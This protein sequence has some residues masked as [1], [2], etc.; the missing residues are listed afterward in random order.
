[1][2]L[3]D[4]WLQSN[5]GKRYKIED[6]KNLQSDDIA[7]NPKL[8][9]FIQLFNLD[10]DG[11]GQVSVKNSKGMNEWKSIFTELKNAAGDDDI[12]TDAELN[13]YI[14]KKHPNIDITAS[15][16]K[17]FFETSTIQKT[18]SY[19]DIFGNFITDTIK[20]NKLAERSISRLNEDGNIETDVVYYENEKPSK[21]LKIIDKYQGEKLSE[22][23]ITEKDEKNNT[24]TTFVTYTNEK[25]SKQVHKTNDEVNAIVTYDYSEG[26][27]SPKTTI[28]SKDKKGIREEVE[29][30]DNKRIVTLYKSSGT[31]EN[32]DKKSSK[33][34]VQSVKSGKKVYNAEY[35][36]KGNTFITVQ[37]DETPETI[38][39]VFHVKLSSLLAVNK[40]L[41]ADSSLAMGSKLLIPVELEADSKYNAGRKTEGQ[42]KKQVFGSVID[43]IYA[44]SI[45]EYKIP[46]N[47]AGK[48]VYEYAEKSLLRK[49][50]K[51]NDPKFADKKDRLVM[52]LMALNGQK[53]D[54]TAGNK[55]KYVKKTLKKETIQE[56]TSA[57]MPANEDNQLFYARFNY[58]SP[59]QQKNVISVLKQCQAKGI[60][61]SQKINAEILK[62]YP[63]LNLFDTDVKKVTKPTKA[64][65]RKYLA[66]MLYAQIYAIRDA[67]ESTTYWK[68][69][70]PFLATAMNFDDW[71]Q[72]GVEGLNDML[73]TNMFSGIQNSDTRRILSAK[74]KTLF[75]KCQKL[76]ILCDMEEKSKDESFDK[77]KYTYDYSEKEFDKLY[78][79]IAGELNYDKIQDFITTLIKYEQAPES[80]RKNPQSK[81]NQQLKI[82]AK[83]RGALPNFDKLGDRVQRYTGNIEGGA[84]LVDLAFNTLLMYV[85]GGGML[86]GKL[87]ESWG[88][89]AAKST[90]QYMTKAATTKFGQSLAG[91]YLL[92]ET[93]QNVVS[94]FMSQQMK[95]MVN[96]PLSAAFFT[97]TKVTDALADG[98]IDMNDVKGIIQSY[99]GLTKFIYLSSNIAS[100]SGA[101]V[102]Y[103]IGNT[104]SRKATLMIV[105]GAIKTPTTAKSV[106]TALAKNSTKIGNVSEFLTSFGMNA[107]IMAVQDGIS[108]GDAMLNLGQMD[109]VSKMVIAMVSRKNM[110]FPQPNQVKRV[111]EELNKYE[112]KDGRISKDGWEVSF[113]NEEELTLI[114]I[115]R[116]L[117]EA[118]RAGI[119]VSEWGDTKG[120]SAQDAHLL[121][122]AKQIEQQI[123]NNKEPFVLDD[124]RKITKGPDGIYR[125]VINAEGKEIVVRADSVEKFFKIGT[126]YKVDETTGELIKIS[127]TENILKP[128]TKEELNELENGI[129]IK[130]SEA[131]MAKHK[132]N[133]LKIAEVDVDIAKAVQERNDYIYGDFVADYIIEAAKIDK[134]LTLKFLSMTCKRSLKNRLN[135][136]TEKLFYHLDNVLDA[137]KSAKVDYNLTMEIVNFAR[138][139][140]LITNATIPHVLSLA[141]VDKDV[142]FKLYKEKR[143]INDGDAIH[144]ISSLKMNRELTLK[145]LEMKDGYG[146][147]LN[148]RRINTIVYAHKKD[149][150]FMANIHKQVL[151]KELKLDEYYDIATAI[152]MLGSDFAYKKVEQLTNAQKRILL[153]KISGWKF[154]NGRAKIIDEMF[155]C[156]PKTTDSD[157]IINLINRLTKELNAKPQQLPENKLV[158]FNTQI[159]KLYSNIDT[160]S[161]KTIVDEFL[162]E[163]KE[164]IDNKNLSK[165]SNSIKRITNDTDFSKL[166]ENDKKI[167]I[168][169]S[170]LSNIKSKNDTQLSIAEKAYNTAFKFGFSESDAKTIYSIT[171]TSNLIKQ[172]MSTSKGKIPH[173]YMNEFDITHRETIFNQLAFK[174]KEGN[175]FNLA[176]LVYSSVEQE[177]LTRFLDKLLEQKINEMKADDFVLYQTPAE[178]Y[179]AKAHKE[180]IT[181][182][183]TG[184]NYDVMVVNSDEIENF[185]AIGHNT[186][187]VSLLTGDVTEQQKYAKLTTLENITNDRAYCG[188]YMDGE[189]ICAINDGFIFVVPNDKFY[190]ASGHDIG[191]LGK[192]VPE[193]INEYFIKNDVEATTH[194]R[195]GETETKNEERKMVSRNIKEIMGIN[196]EEYIKRLDNIKSKLQGKPFTPDNVKAIDLE[197]ANAYKEFLSRVN[198][199][200]T[201]GKRALLSDKEWNEVIVSN[202][203]IGGIY[204]R[205]L[206]GLSE[207]KLIFARDNN[208]PIVVLRKKSAVNINNKGTNNPSEVKPSPQ[209]SITDNNPVGQV[210]PHKNSDIVTPQSKNPVADALAQ[211]EAQAR[212]GILPAVEKIEMEDT[213]G[214]SYKASTNPLAGTET[215]F[216]GKKCATDKKELRKVFT[217]AGADLKDLET[218]RFLDRVVDK[219]KTKEDF[220]KASILVQGGMVNNSRFRY[221]FTLYF[222]KTADS[223]EAAI[224]NMLWTKGY[225]E[226]GNLCGGG[227]SYNAENVAKA[228]KENPVLYRLYAEALPL[229]TNLKEYHNQN[230]A[231]KLAEI[232]Q[233]IK[234]EEH[235]DAMLE[236]LKSD[237]EAKNAYPLERNLIA[238]TIDKYFDAPGKKDSYIKLYKNLSQ[239]DYRDYSKLLESPEKADAYYELITSDKYNFTPDELAELNRQVSSGYYHANPQ[240][241]KILL[242]KNIDLKNAL[243]AEQYINQVNNLEFT[244]AIMESNNISEI[245]QHV[246]KSKWF[247]NLGK[248][249][250]NNLDGM[251][252][253]CANWVDKKIDT[254]K[255]ATCIELKDMLHPAIFN[256]MTS[257][258][259]SS[260]LKHLVKDGIIPKDNIERIKTFSRIYREGAGFDD[261]IYNKAKEY[262]STS[263]SQNEYTLLMYYKIVKEGLDK[264]TIETTLNNAKAKKNQI[265]SGLEDITDNDIEK[266]F[267]ENTAGIQEAIN[268]IGR[269]AFEYSFTSKFDGM[270]RLCEA[271][272]E[273]YK[274]YNDLI[275][276]LNDVKSDKSIEPKM[277][278]QRLPE[279][280]K[281]IADEA[282][283][284]N[285]I[286]TALSD[287][288]IEPQDKIKKLETLGALKL[289]CNSEEFNSF[290]DLIKPNKP[291]S[292]QVQQAVQIWS[293]PKAFYEDKWNAF[294]EAFGVE[295]DNA[296]VKAFFEKRATVNA[297]GFKI[298]NGVK[299]ADMQQFLSSI[300]REQN[301]KVWNNAINKKVFD[302]VGA[303]YTEDVSKKLELASSPDLDLILAAEDGFKSNF[304]LMIVRLGEQPE[305]S[306]KE[307]F[308]NLPQNINT[309][310]QYAEHHVDY[311]KVTTPDKDSYKTVKIKVDA[312]KTRQNCVTNLV[313]EF[314]D[315]SFQSLPK[316]ET[317]EI[318]NALKKELGI[319]LK[320]ILE[321][322]YDADGYLI[323]EKEVFQFFNA[324]GS[325]ITFNNLGKMM[326]VIKKAINANDFWS[327]KNPNAQIEQ[328]RNTFYDHIMK[329]RDEEISN[330]ENIKSDKTTEVSIQQVDM[331]EMPYGL[332]LGAKLCCTSPTGGNGF[333]APTYVMNKCIGAFD[334]KD[335]KIPVGNTMMYLAEIE[336]R[337]ALVLDNIEVK[338][339]YQDNVVRDAFMDYVKEWCA[340]KGLR[341]IPIYAGPNRH[342][343]EMGKSYPIEKH[344]VKIIGSTGLDEIYIDYKGKYIVDGNSSIDNVNMY[345]IRPPK[346]EPSPQPS[347]TGNNPV[348]QVTPDRNGGVHTAA[349][350]GNGIGFNPRVAP[351]AQNPVSNTVNPQVAKI[352]AE[353]AGQKINAIKLKADIERS[354]RKNLLDGFEALSSDK[355]LSIDEKIFALLKDTKDN[356]KIDQNKITEIRKEIQTLAQTNPEEARNLELVL[357]GRTTTKK[358]SETTREEISAIVQHLRRQFELEKA[359]ITANLERLGAKELGT[360][361][362]RVKSDMS[363]F[364]KIANFALNNPDKPFEMAVR[365]VR[366][367]YGGRIELNSV[368]M[369]NA[370][371]EVQKLVNEGKTDEAGKLAM[372]KI[373]VQVADF[374]RKI[375]NDPK[376]AFEITRVSNYKDSA[377]I[378]MLDKVKMFELQKEAL[379]SGMPIVVESWQIKQQGSAYPAFQV[380]VKTKSGKVLE[381]QIRLDEVGQYAEIEHYIYDLMTG[382]DIIGRKEKVAPLFEPLEKSLKENLTEEEYE[383][384][385]LP[386]TR[387]QYHHRLLKA[388]GID[389]PEPRL[390]DFPA[391]PGKT[392][393]ARLKAENLFL[394]H[395]LEKKVKDEELTS[396]QALEIYN[397]AVEESTIPQN[398]ANHTGLTT[399]AQETQDIL[400][401]QALQQNLKENNV[402]YEIMQDKEGNQIIRVVSDYKF[403]DING[404]TDIKYNIY[405]YEKDGTVTKTEN[406]PQKEVKAKFGKNWK[407]VDNS[408]SSNSGTLNSTLIPFSSNLRIPSWLKNSFGFGL[409]SHPA[410]K[411]SDITKPTKQAKFAKPLEQNSPIYRDIN[412][413]S[414][415]L[416]AKFEEQAGNITSSEIQEIVKNI[417]TKYNVSEDIVLSI[418][419]RLTQFGSYKQLD[420]LGARLKEMGI[421]KFYIES[422]IARNDTMTDVSKKTSLIGISTNA[423]LYYI[424][425]QKEQ[426]SLATGTGK[427]ALILD[428]ASLK[429]MEKLKQNN[430]PEYNEILKNIKT[431]TLVLINLDGTGLQVENQY[432]S[433]T[434]F[435][436]GQNLASLTEAVLQQAN[437]KSKNLNSVLNSSFAKR[438]EALFGIDIAQKIEN[439][440]IESQAQNPETISAQIRQKVPSSD[441]IKMTIDEI[442]NQRLGKDCSQIDRITATTAL[443]KY[444]DNFGRIYSSEGMAELLKTR[445][446]QIQQI[447]Q[448][449]GKS[450]D[451]VVFFAPYINKSFGLIAQMYSK[452][453]DIPADNF[454]VFGG[455]HHK[456][457][458]RNDAALPDGKVI[459]LLDDVIGS[460]NSALS[461]LVMNYSEFVQTHPNSN[462]IF[463]P[464]VCANS[465]IKAITE[466]ISGKWNGQDRTGKDFLLVDEENMFSLYDSRY[467]AGDMPFN[468]KYSIDSN[469]LKN[470]DYQKMP[471]PSFLTEKDINDI[472]NGKVISGTNGKIPGCFNEIKEINMFIKLNNDNDGYGNNGLCITFPYMTPD[473]SCSISAPLLLH[474]LS[475]PQDGTNLKAA[476][477]SNFKIVNT[478]IANKNNQ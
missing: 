353:V 365:D 397:K 311:D 132:Q 395:D 254:E 393:D 474:C 306:V 272:E 316:E 359:E 461:Q 7:K 378:T 400:T 437:G 72:Q 79:E 255:L 455:A 195:S 106:I 218:Q 115:D 234:T 340:E 379:D 176:K 241:I 367:N 40:G 335:G 154:Q 145:L 4:F 206:A 63:E 162:P 279:L 327:K 170:I 344:D 216:N 109:A 127:K 308:D 6:L 408:V 301:Q 411:I 99:E 203:K 28:I 333:S 126:E 399:T 469:A 375:I 103:L 108:Y 349:Q 323:G 237:I 135:N 283:L 310:R 83:K 337:T 185:Y 113:K 20:D 45:S 142:A 116:T 201:Q 361:T 235:V 314:N 429:Y 441:D 285:S 247:D 250:Q 436:G 371:P 98:S 372:E 343:F 351:Q 292:A 363:E 62:Y 164:N 124:N 233:F 189:N 151:S 244:S 217:D 392:F 97:G 89:M 70:H 385:Y 390:E 221:R 451:D 68:K 377:N 402:S 452:V 449:L 111:V 88:T 161:I 177:G 382:K 245:Y 180:T 31:I 467:N 422:Y 137:V 404:M 121:G 364:D 75:D 211:R 18:E 17:E 41:K 53:A 305:M 69:N 22:R 104:A 238:A 384:Y 418:I 198:T 220:I 66:Q 120:M 341:D 471:Y 338:S 224:L 253:Y 433:Y 406:I 357:N 410:I 85:S 430:D 92:G 186:D 152:N 143:Q 21:K 334:I 339:G 26:N 192:S 242:D 266:F 191:S 131:D 267:A 193:I 342:K 312:E 19:S 458:K 331:N 27:E 228:I 248:T 478:I 153:D 262:L 236:M 105:S 320:T 435:D 129:N 91:K 464:I 12:L 225:E 64:M 38:A 230:Q 5:N 370:L 415:Y 33:K 428:D 476:D 444:Y 302:V 128:A 86:I 326:S 169:S 73:G 274:N 403:D 346:P 286:K 294:C 271:A 226:S 409:N 96:A 446:N 150:D 401:L 90:T 252:N 269:P 281:M 166:S 366:D 52:E 328:N 102:K 123:E 59:A 47:N 431:G 322:Q 356:S 389:T 456:M 46:E 256:Q 48:D 214:I 13:T 82:A 212:M 34:L 445:H 413:L 149:P 30:P 130:L 25:I 74:V 434:A 39:K 146:N 163:Y 282:K 29:F 147:K 442:I 319:E 475:N 388:L 336:G 156:L 297:K 205:N 394:L 276:V 265:K 80:E 14:R 421:E 114:L 159:E 325:P 11:D 71:L 324:D 330:A 347:I 168:I 386:Y 61:D 181:G 440:N 352:T 368:D 1:M 184:T 194:N 295:K 329:S 453:N 155:P 473:N 2:G 112:I 140:N 173:N 332:M 196:D 57:G 466:N 360:F 210:T 122:Y 396:D 24:K 321:P 78:K 391:P 373:S 100:P 298:L 362:N 133:F 303:T 317:Q 465:G 383:T 165:I 460:G 257:G 148:S 172:F 54:Y 95:A 227:Q 204:T 8:Q 222:E 32:F 288:S 439:I 448:N 414:E 215:Y 183:K 81:I 167:T 219:C 462:I 350:T 197:F 381:I 387:A 278:E 426:F 307:T 23:T 296:K 190:A 463:S 345:V 299:S 117:Y 405:K 470:F 438:I 277:L 144:C 94:S 315:V 424:Q 134:K 35:D 412:K 376:H 374:M 251:R 457:S 119:D 3:G 101:I 107:E 65:V 223:K 246:F 139:N 291:T 454:V 358:C 15:E 261:A 348:G 76:M 84:G 138:E 171:E 420:V 273:L 93:S 249:T 313:N 202:P 36:G 136:K 263:E 55:I 43:K 270:E 118:S 37:K 158:E 423:S 425:S 369:K 284:L 355:A 110:K 416:S 450:M 67:L 275:R 472:N 477:S 60:K 141:L 240:R 419:S 175:T 9:K 209:P 50:V 258:M 239:F 264:E 300:V 380:N 77:K 289:H 179:I 231:Y 243:E 56:L 182:N 293:N 417:S 268:L 260:C 58:L 16:V 125:L 427:E 443:G 178:E 304:R 199:D 309:K 318:L 44:S 187:G 87:A 200:E 160:N 10:S 49:G 290:I 208:I 232:A 42:I 468:I 432:F 280:E 213:Y 407:I 447:V 229:I 207:E 188:F 259:F 174:L 398:P 51:Q 459:V 354:V 157:S 287:K